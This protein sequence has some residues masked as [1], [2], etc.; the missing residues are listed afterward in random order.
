MPHDALKTLYYSHLRYAI[1]VWGNATNMN[2]PKVIQKRAI[3]IINKSDFRGHTEPLFKSEEI[4]KISDLHKLHV[5]LFMFGLQSDSLPKYF[6]RLIP[7]KTPTMK[8][9]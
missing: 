6:H 1:Q 4:S 9:Q 8:T 2:A 7:K 5:S 3:R